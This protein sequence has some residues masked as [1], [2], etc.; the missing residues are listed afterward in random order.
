MTRKST[1]YS[2]ELTE[3]VTSYKVPSGLTTDL[4]TSSNNIEVGS[5]VVMPRTLQ[6]SVVKILMDAPRLISVFGKE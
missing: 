3:I 5:K 2:Q 6:V 4:S 1:G